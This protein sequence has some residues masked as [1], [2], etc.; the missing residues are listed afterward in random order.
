MAGRS[1]K[2]IFCS[3][4]R[5][6]AVGQRGGRVPG[7]QLRGLRHYKSLLWAVGCGQPHTLKIPAAVKL[8]VINA[9]FSS[10]RFSKL[11]FVPFGWGRAWSVLVGPGPGPFN[12]SLLSLLLW[13]QDNLIVESN[14]CVFAFSLFS[15]FFL[16]WPCAILWGLLPF[17]YLLPLSL[18]RHSFDQHPGRYPGRK[19]RG[20]LFCLLFGELI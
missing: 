8:N 6:S 3:C 12:V 4:A 19:L 20:G 2:F 16:V 1:T 9:I 17:R 11:V 18:T 5:P 13:V 15:L 10:I 7:F 14:T